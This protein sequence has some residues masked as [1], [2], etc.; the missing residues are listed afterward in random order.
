MF[1]SEAQYM[2]ASNGCAMFV[3][4]LLVEVQASLSY[5]R[6]MHVNS[7]NKDLNSDS[8]SNYL[9]VA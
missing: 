6:D 8:G 5:S 9:L 2:N 4:K 1:V 3:I 7:W